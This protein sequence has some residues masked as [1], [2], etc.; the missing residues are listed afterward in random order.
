[1]ADY[2]LND[3][4]ISVNS[5]RLHSLIK[6]IADYFEVGIHPGFGSNQHKNK[7]KT[8]H[9]R[10]EVI[11]KREVTKSR[12]HFLKISFPDTYRNLI[13]LNITDD[14]TMGF[15]SMAG[16]RSS[17]CTSFYFY[18]LDL[19]IKSPLK[20]HPFAVME[21]T[22]NDYM[23]LSPQDAIKELKLLID[24]VREVDGTFSS[25]W[26]NESL[27]DSKNWI[28]WRTVYEEMVKYASIDDK[29]S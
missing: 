3:K 7:L 2:G 20:I 5:R 6:S 4:N 28:G 10:L 1:M 8:E 25:L 21:A 22:L 14:Y 9:R 11:L 17:I 24:E 13:E 29:V 15:A 26:H 19:E 23:Q 18:D 16:F 12:Q 27:S